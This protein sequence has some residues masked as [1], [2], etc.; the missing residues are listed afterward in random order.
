MEPTIFGYI[1]RYS[2]RQQM[3][4]L[5]VTLASFPFL[6]YSLDLPKTIINEAI[7]GEEFPQ[8]FLGFEM[9]QTEYLL[10][11]CFIFLSLVLINGGF[12]L[13]INIYRG[14]MGERMLRRLRYMLFARILRFPMPQFR[15]TSQGEII[16][17]IT[18]E[19][20]PLGGYIGEAISLPAFQG[21]TLL[22]ILVF[23]MIQDPFLGIAAIAL[24][25][26]QMYVIP[27]LQKRVNELGKQRVRTVRRLSERVGETVTGVQEVHTHDT[28]AF[29]LADIS[30][31]LG[32]IFFIRLEIFKR[33]FF[34]KFLNN[35]IAQVTPFLFYSIG[36]YL[37]IQGDLSFG[38]L[39]AVLAAYKDL[40][41]PWK[42]LLTH[43]QVA[44]DARIK[45]EQLI[46]QFQPTGML[47]EEL[48]R[49]PV[50]EKL[51]LEG[52]IGISNIVVEDD[53]G[54]KTL[55]SANAQIPLKG[56]TA[57]VGT[58][59][60]ERDDLVRLLV[61]LVSPD[62]GRA[63][64][65]GR[66]IKEIHEGVLGDQTAY[67][68]QS[69]HMFNG[70]IRDNLFYGLKHRQVG[71]STPEGVDGR[72][73]SELD[74]EAA[75]SGNSKDDVDAVWM[76]FMALDLAG[77][78]AVA[79]HALDVLKVCG[80]ERDMREIALQ[81]SVDPQSHPELAGRILEARRELV[82]RLKEPK[83]ASLVEPFDKEKYN[84]NMTV[85]ENIL[86][87][88][89]V[90]D[91]FNTANLGT[92]P[93][94]LSVLDKVGIRGLFLEAG[95]KVAETMIELF[96]DLPPGHEFFERYSFI[97]ADELP[98]FQGILRR[99]ESSG[100]DKLEEAEKAQLMGLT[101]V[102]VPDRHRLGLGTEEIKQQL[103]QARRSF[104]DDLPEE[105]EGAVKFYDVE[106][107]NDAASVIDNI[108]FGKIMHGRA[109]AHQEVNQIISDV[110]EKLELWP[111][112]IELGLDS[113]VGVGGGR[114]SA[115]QRQKLSLARALIKKPQ[116]LVLND[117][118]SAL[119]PA[120]QDQIT[121]GVL[122]AYRD[123]AL[124]WVVNRAE[125][126]K[127]FDNVIVM[128]SGKVIEQGTTSELDKEGS[129]FHKRL[130]A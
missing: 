36:G 35:F 118:L 16:S 41:P 129:E 25:P 89:P 71:E 39:V 87:G 122:E 6:Y 126:A 106:E 8:E 121:N 112:L 17:M 97:Q 55:D 24:Y 78:D 105:L 19:V 120:S 63:N 7:G 130:I 94:L 117:P 45:Y 83:L 13:W 65:N 15:K 108:L 47:P 5:A 40:S 74:G 86:M 49:E 52:D 33:K 22:T 27:K 125:L 84:N 76:D 99:A 107:Y 4:L 30:A 64:I 58:S 119:D 72:S 48:Q 38:A 56:T 91:I 26:V 123:K 53:S 95:A 92:H 114:L 90:G 93:Y 82:A 18:A 23:I 109:Q 62:S 2:R 127:R 29:E 101:F 116:L 77:E 59:E 96:Q 75:V 12:K 115:V 98:E 50:G 54:I 70:T 3:I 42:E 1:W 79:N 60:S 9:G 67:V 43:Y 124:I 44:L 102:L 104:A 113:Q 34:I 57:I 51:S 46:E 73:R 128:D 21:G 32:K 20:E 88:T 81:T 85:A 69:A 110:I 111:T 103:L 11:L 31:W 100:L 28:S 66:D 68:D 10:T 14:G 37:V 80:L 61:R